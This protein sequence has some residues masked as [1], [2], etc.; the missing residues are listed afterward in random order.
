VATL[1]DGEEPPEL[2]VPIFETSIRPDSDSEIE[3]RFWAPAE[4]CEVPA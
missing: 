3:W 2:I 1:L 4:P